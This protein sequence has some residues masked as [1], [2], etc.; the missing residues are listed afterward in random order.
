MAD[1]YFHFTIGPVQQFVAQARRTRDFWSGSFL[2]SFMA[3]VAMQSVRQQGGEIEFPLP[4]EHYLNWLTGA[5]DEQQPPQQGCIPN[6]FKAARVKVPATFDPR[7]VINDMQTAW[8]ALARLIWEEDLAH[9]SAEQQQRTAPVW[10]RQVEHF[11]D[12]SWC[13]SADKRASNLLDRRKNWRTYQPPPEPGVSC[14]MM[15]GW[16]EL[17]GQPRPG[18]GVQQFWRQLRDRAGRGMQ[19]DLREGENL[20]AI[21][22]IKRRFARYFA[23]FTA[24]LGQGATAWTLYG[25]ELPVQVPSVNYMAA[26]PWLAHTLRASQANPELHEA[27]RLMQADIHAL[28]PA[29]EGRNF[30]LARITQACRQSNITDWHNMNGRYYYED[31]LDTLI[32]RE[33]DPATVEL[34]RSA[35]QHLRTIQRHS[36]RPSDFYAILLMDGDSLGS[37]M[38][39]AAKQQ[40]ISQALNQFTRQVPDVVTQHSGFLVYA[41]GDDVLALLALDDALACA[42]ALRLTYQ[43]CFAAV[44]ADLANAPI[45]TSLSGA[46]LLCHYKSP[47]TQNL[48]KAHPLLDD[49][50]KEATGRNSLALAVYKPGGRHC[51]WSSPWQRSWAEPAESVSIVALLQQLISELQRY[52]QEDQQFSRKFICKLE[53]LIEQLGLTAPGHGFERA[54]LSALIRAAWEHTGKR[55]DALLDNLIEA[56]LRLLAH[57]QPQQSQ[58]AEQRLSVDALKL[59]HFFATEQTGPALD[60]E[61]AR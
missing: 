33:P 20:C 45:E 38:S 46:L 29:Q 52:Q 18:K 2:L 36:G 24:V 21:G 41:G 53:Q 23:K 49:I 56:L 61:D 22:F 59:L 31:E 25:W 16:Q 50:A 34:L 43:D 3:S 51:Q 4:D 30:T 60:M 5:D 39:D 14:M 35:R 9:L 47:L 7:Q 48:G 8:Q 32:S 28:D 54:T 11:W 19:M 37:Q 42:E 27:L 55:T 15:E 13:L 44:N 1:N 17:S 58:Q 6:R 26:L 40:G 12:I 10:Q 57:W